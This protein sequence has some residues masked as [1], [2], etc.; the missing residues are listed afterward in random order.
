MRH[1]DEFVCERARA[2]TSDVTARPHGAAH[3][4]Y[5]S[6]PT[7]IG[8]QP[9]PNT[10]TLHPARLSAPPVSASPIAWASLN[11]HRPPRQRAAVVLRHYEDRS[12]AETAELL[13][14]SVGNVKALTSRGLAALRVAMA[15][16]EEAS[17]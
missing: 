15:P 14:C 8:Y 13:G 9:L 5:H 12:E 2:A 10:D 17:R 11:V 16:A 4:R 1:D 6:Y 3:K 7:T